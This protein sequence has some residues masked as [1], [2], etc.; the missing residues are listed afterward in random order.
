MSN[1]NCFQNKPGKDAPMEDRTLYARLENV[2]R[3][4]TTFN[5][6]WKT[7][8]C[9][10][11]SSPAVP[12][13]EFERFFNAKD[14]VA[15]VRK[16]WV[17]RKMYLNPKHGGYQASYIFKD[18]L[19]PQITR[20]KKLCSWLDNHLSHMLLALAALLLFI[21]VMMFP[22]KLAHAS[23]KGQS[24]E[25]VVKPG[26]GALCRYESKENGVVCFATCNE[27]TLSCVRILPTLPAEKISGKT[28]TRDR[29]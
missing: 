15:C 3:N 14:R 6:R 19:L 5:V 13:A 25:T 20:F 1:Q 23:G 9:K 28:K 21:F 22:F 26:F 8:V 7:R 27:K 16:G 17:E 10:D 11:Y 4:Y 12:A 29:E 24:H 2:F 18:C